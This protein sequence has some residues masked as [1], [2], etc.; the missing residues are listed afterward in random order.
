MGG[1]AIELNTHRVYISVL[2]NFRAKEKDTASCP[3]SNNNA[4]AHSAPFEQRRRAALL[5]NA[6]WLPAPRKPFWTAT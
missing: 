3:Y 1:K 2:N 4:V 5:K 6:E